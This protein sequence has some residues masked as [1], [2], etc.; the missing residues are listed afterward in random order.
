MA[1][2]TD[3]TKTAGISGLLPQAYRRLSSQA[4]LAGSD[5]ATEWRG[6]MERVADGGKMGG[7]LEKENAELRQQLADNAQAESERI[8][9]TTCACVDD[10]E[11]K[12]PVCQWWLEAEND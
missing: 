7:E 8:G 2:Q 11:A 12:P 1:K 3:L 4:R 6:E 9:C 5:L 10:C